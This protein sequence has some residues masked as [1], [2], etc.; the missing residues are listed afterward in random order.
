VVERFKSFNDAPSRTVIE[1]C[2]YEY[3]VFPLGYEGVDN[4]EETHQAVLDH[5]DVLNSHD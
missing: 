3:E 5:A 1:P 4:R 2:V